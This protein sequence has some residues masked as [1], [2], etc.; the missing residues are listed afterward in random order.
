MDT[1]P[2]HFLLFRA[3]V[4][5]S[6]LEA[7]RAVAAQAVLDVCETDDDGMSVVHYAAMYGDCAMLRYLVHELSNNASPQWLTVQ[8]KRKNT[9]LHLASLSGSLDV[10]RF[11]VEHSSADS[12]VLDAKNVWDE[13]ALHL[14]AQS[15]N[16]A[17]FSLL[18]ERCSNDVRDKWDRT[19]LQ[20]AQEHMLG[21]QEVIRKSA[22][23][24]SAPTLTK[25]SLSKLMEAPLN[26]QQFIGWLQDP[27]ID[28]LGKDMFGLTAA[29]KLAAWNLDGLLR[30]LIESGADVNAQDSNG[31]TP[32]MH[33][34]SMGADRTA[35][36]LLKTKQVD[37][38]IRNK[39][40]QTAQ[41]MTNLKEYEI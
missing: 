11:I 20:V 23:I 16:E 24:S 19:P 2:S 32:L 4:I 34:L 35:R 39:A 28:L 18:K 12:A 30:L 15:L 13:T 31:E 27:Q 22:T 6:D 10:V 33:A 36:L 38:S 9:P 7:A 25:K 26:A 17:V 40:G 14:A 8:N 37:R 41:E 3:A 5:K 29:H 21:R 1:S